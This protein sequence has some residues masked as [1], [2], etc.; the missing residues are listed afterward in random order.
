MAGWMFFSVFNMNL[1]SK[2]CSSQTWTYDEIA[3]EFT[4]H[5]DDE[6]PSCIE[7]CKC[8]KGDRVSMDVHPS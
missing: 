5:Y 2:R 1:N 8:F 3:C 7:W 4:E 6:T